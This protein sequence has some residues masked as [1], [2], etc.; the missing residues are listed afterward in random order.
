MSPTWWKR[1]QC[2]GLD[3]DLG[4]KRRVAVVDFFPEFQLRP[5]NVPG[6][7]QPEH[8]RAAARAGALMG[9]IKARTW[10]AK[11]WLS[12]YVI[13]K[14]QQPSDLSAWTAQLAQKFCLK[15]TQKKIGTG[16]AG[17]AARLISQPCDSSWKRLSL[18]AESLQAWRAAGSCSHRQP[19]RGGSPGKQTRGPDVKWILFNE[20][21]C[22]NGKD[23]GPTTRSRMT[24]LEST[25]RSNLSSCP[26][27]L[28]W[29]L[30]CDRQPWC[31]II[32]LM[33]RRE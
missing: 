12:G 27:S 8:V 2:V 14:T 7:E 3:E 20:R 19:R 29:S 5:R 33:L 11:P 9:G 21:L 17:G 28:L 22:S 32:W 23:A 15:E 25:T 24:S 13:R 10:G 4:N 16:R 1:L 18:E 6:L 31:F 30:M 26:V